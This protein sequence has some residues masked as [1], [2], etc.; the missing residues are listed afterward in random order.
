MSFMCYG[1]HTRQHVLIPG[2]N[3]LSTKPRRFSRLIYHHAVR[4][5]NSVSGH[6]WMGRGVFEGELGRELAVDSAGEMDSRRYSVDESGHL[7]SHFTDLSRGFATR[8]SILSA[9]GAVSAL[10]V[11]YGAVI[12]LLRGLETLCCLSINHICRKI[13]VE[14]NSGL[15][16]VSCSK[17]RI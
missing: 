16:W 15:S 14:W 4:V 1:A 10:S 11:S 5:Q 8:S 2:H 3:L 9:G 6:C 12:E 13:Q 17:L 7:A